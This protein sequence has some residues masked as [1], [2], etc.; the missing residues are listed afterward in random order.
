MFC[1]FIV[2]YFL[3]RLVEARAII[4]EGA[5]AAKINERLWVHVFISGTAEPGSPI[6]SAAT[7]VNII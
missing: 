2:S 4:R 3:L 5:V 1:C 7:W 6:E